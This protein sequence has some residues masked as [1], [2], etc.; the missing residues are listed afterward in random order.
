MLRC[1]EVVRK[2]RKMVMVVT[3]GIVSFRKRFG[4]CHVVFEGPGTA[5]ARARRQLCQ[6]VKLYKKS[7]LAHRQ[8]AA[9]NRHWGKGRVVGCWLVVG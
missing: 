3:M 6:S 5:R 8:V 2:K 7:L 1:I 4:G 9:S